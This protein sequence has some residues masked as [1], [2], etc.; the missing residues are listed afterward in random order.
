[1]N[2]KLNNFV[3]IE[4]EKA[5]NL[6]FCR[7]LKLLHIR[8]QVEEILNSIGK[9]SIFEEYTVHNILHIDEMLKIVKWLIPDETKNNMTSAEWLMLTLAIYFHDLGMIVTKDEYEKRNESVAFQKYKENLEK[10]SIK[11]EYID[12]AT[13]Q[14]DK[15]LYQEFVRENH[16]KRIKQWIEG[17][18]DIDL[19][20]T[21]TIRKVVDDILINI[22]K[23][24]RVDLAM[25]CESHH[26]DDIDDF[27]KYKVDMVYG[28]DKNEKVNLNYIAIIL[29]I[30]DLLH[31]TKDRT[32]SITRKLINVSNPVSVIEWEKQSAV[33]A[34]QPKVKRDDEENVNNT[35]EK[36][37]IEI[38]AYFEG[39]ETADAYFGLSSYLQYMR[40]E[41]Q[42]CNEIVEKARKKEGTIN[43]KFPWREIDESRIT[44]IGFETKKLQFTIAQDN[45]LQ[46][47]VGHT[48]YNDSSVVVRELVQNGID[49]VKLQ[50]AIDEKKENVFENGEVQV[51]W[52]EDERELTFWDNG[53]GMTIYDVENYL[54]KVGASKYRTDVVKKQFPNFS[55]ISHFGIGILTCFMVADDIDIETSS[56]EEDDVICINLRKVNG[57]YLLKRKN[58]RDVDIRIRN[59][60]TMVK[61]YIRKDVNMS[62]IEYDL[63]KWIVLPE[64][65]VYYTEKDK[66]KIRVGYESL[67]DALK[68]YLNDSGVNVDGK[69]YDVYEVT[70]GNVTLAYAVRYLKYLSDWCLIKINNRSIRK[71]N[72]LPTGTCVE[73]IRVEFTTPGYKNTSILAIANIKNSKYQTNVARSAIELDANSEILSN[74]Y[75]LYSQYIQDQIVKLEELEYSN[76]WALS[77]GNY[78]MQ[79]LVNDEFGSNRMEP[80]DETILIKQMAKIKCISLENN[81]V[82]KNVSAEDVYEMDEIN[83]FESKMTQAIENL[84]KEI[85][86]NATLKSLVEV[87]CSENNFTKDVRNIICNY[88]IY[89]ILHQYALSN[90]DVRQIVIDHKQRR[91]KLTYSLKNDIWHEF[92]LKTRGIV[93]K[94]FVPKQEFVIDGLQEEIGV[95]TQ[96]AIFLQSNSEICRYILK[97]INDFLSEDTGEN[98]ILLQLFL[99]YIFNSQI[100]ER[101]FSNTINKEIVARQMMEEQHVQIS[102]ELLG[103]MWDKINMEEFRKNVLLQNYSLYSIDNWSRKEEFM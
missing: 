76:T 65:P 85:K 16:A 96:G 11:S 89:N 87:V 33:R 5:E 36:D 12:F 84:L 51:E 48:L 80:I 73:G 54:L 78:L 17:T 50:R 88:D 68:K 39:S 6:S 59:H 63:K 28:N 42:I 1:M 45:I 70:Q 83:I 43:Y 60:G 4:A 52:N 21:S 102:D 90:K 47:L 10:E 7:G 44:V 86:S 46:L 14:G 32:P 57:S 61:L 41:L 53:T 82:R 38:T 99:G 92:D 22:D 81:G 13:K 64:V 97:I 25:I 74:I 66:N 3:E 103:K 18:S 56:N 93:K 101:K 69:E 2:N 98:K 67:K 27:T 31:I 95:K 9:G 35:L 71:K 40:K 100:L 77:E 20:I 58:K 23:M 8:D 91:I 24:F 49:A 15:F 62:T 79:P 94:L 55:S 75:H 34:V 30:A 37:T 72:L 26:M 19:G 29:R